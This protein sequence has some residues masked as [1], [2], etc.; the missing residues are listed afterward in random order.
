M[1][2]NVLLKIFQQGVCMMCDN[3]TGVVW[4]ASTGQGG[5]AGNQ[6][7]LVH[8]TRVLHKYGTALSDV[9]ACR[10]NLAA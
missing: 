9:T 1:S 10:D 5:K 4:V 3:E 7:V 6:V 2:S 8:I